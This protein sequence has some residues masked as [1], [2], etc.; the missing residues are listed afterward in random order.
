MSYKLKNKS[1]RIGI[2]IFLAIQ[3]RTSIIKDIQGSTNFHALSS[4]SN[5]Q[6]ITSSSLGAICVINKSDTSWNNGITLSTMSEIKGRTFLSTNSII[7][8]KTSITNSINHLRIG[9]KAFQ[10]GFIIPSNPMS[11]TCSI[12]LNIVGSNSVIFATT[13]SRN[14]I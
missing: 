4:T 14:Q 13:V 12:M 7:F 2:I 8:W 3:I 6:S 9:S 11:H 5:T 1:I 10:K